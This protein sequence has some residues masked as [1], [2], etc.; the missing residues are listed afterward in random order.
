MPA[1]LLVLLAL[2]AC[3]PDPAPTPA[4]SASAASAETPSTPVSDAD[5]L[6]VEG[7][8]W[9]ADVVE[10]DGD[11]DAQVMLSDVRAARHGGFDRLVFEF[12][13]GRPPVHVE[14]IDRPVRA[15]GSGEVVELP[16]DAWLQ[17][18]F[19]KARAHTEA[20]EAT[21]DAR[22]RELGFSNALEWVSTC[23]FEGEVAY[24]V[25]VAS[26]EPVRVTTL[27]GPPRVAVDVR[28][29]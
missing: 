2:A 19:S 27:E 28:H 22:Q 8:V 14:Y 23:D 9:T 13:G 7:G 3:A 17:V 4:A 12:E 26:P 6:T 11:T 5:T 1:L 25:A 15:C 21:V 10:R 20:G 16:G 29:E 18:R 24:V